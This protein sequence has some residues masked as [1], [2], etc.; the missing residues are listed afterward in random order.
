MASLAIALL[1][2]DRVK[3]ARRLGR[4]HESNM[5]KSAFVGLISHEFRTP[6][7]TIRVSSD[8]IARFRSKLSKKEI[9][10][11]L[12][13]ISDCI[14]RMTK[15][16]GDILL[17][18]KMQNNQIKFN[19]KLVDVVVLFHDIIRD[20]DNVSS[21]R[22]VVMISNIDTECRLMLDQTLIYHIASNLLSNALKYSGDDK[23]VELCVRLDGNWM[24][25]EVLDH[26]IGIPESEVKNLFD[27]FH[28]C[29]NVG[30]RAGIGIGLFMIRQCVDLHR[31]TISLKTSEGIGST[32]M[33]SIPV[34]GNR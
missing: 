14:I 33:V 13:N 34:G 12:K 2:V 16:M 27:L 20:I 28:R 3:L 15:M 18:G 4:E 6:L 25:I 26:G 19:A 30:N 10:D 11:S 8:L 32:F 24:I 17:L 5:M 7:A 22:R 23:K 9:D 31:G 21:R 1:C 29:S